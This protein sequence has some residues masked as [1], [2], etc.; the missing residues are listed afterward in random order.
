GL[1]AYVG[2]SAQD[3]IGTQRLV[4]PANRMTYPGANILRQQ[5]IANTQDRRVGKVRLDP[6]YATRRVAQVSE[7]RRNGQPGIA[8]Q[9]VQ[10]LAADERQAQVVV[11]DLDIHLSGGPLS[12]AERGIGEQLHG[13]QGGRVHGTDSSNGK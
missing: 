10:H 5:R 9:T 11:L 3:L 2:E 13:Q 6:E 7:V 8:H 12:A 4:R 1:A